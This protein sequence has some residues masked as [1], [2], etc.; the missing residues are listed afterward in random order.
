LLM[1]ADE[2]NINANSIRYDRVRNF[3]CAD[4]E[5]KEKLKNNPQHRFHRGQM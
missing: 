3:R 1:A 2:M 5:W 4:N